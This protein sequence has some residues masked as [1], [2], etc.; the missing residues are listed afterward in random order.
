MP[1]DYKKIMDDLEDRQVRL[2]ATRYISAREDDGLLYI[3]DVEQNQI[4]CT[5]NN[6]TYAPMIANALNDFHGHYRQGDNIGEQNIGE[7]T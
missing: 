3:I 7:P 4:V 6:I 2:K 1:H 5:T